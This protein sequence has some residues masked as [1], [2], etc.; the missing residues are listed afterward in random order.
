MKKAE[1]GRVK[2]AALRL[3]FHKSVK[4]CEKGK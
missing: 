3:S 4:K 1:R 2:A